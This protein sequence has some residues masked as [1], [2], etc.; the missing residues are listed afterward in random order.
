MTNSAHDATARNVA[1]GSD[2]ASRLFALS[3]GCPAPAHPDAVVE[4]GDARFT[5]LTD[6]L[7]RIEHRGATPQR[8]GGGRGRGHGGGRG[9]GCGCGGRLHAINYPTFVD[10]RTPL[11]VSRAFPVPEFTVKRGAEDDAVEITTPHLRL[12]YAGGPLTAS[13]LTIA[14]TSANADTH[15]TVWRYGMDL[16]TEWPHRGNLATTARTLDGVDGATE[17]EPGFLA[18]WGFGTLDDSGSPVLTADGWIAPSPCAPDAVDMYFFGHGR[19]YAGA[20]DDFHTLTGPIPM[21]PRYV[22]G[23]WWSRY[24]KYDEPSYLA[25]LDH[26]AAEDIPLSVAVIDMDWHWVDIDPEIGTG[27]TGYSWNTDLFPDPPR[28]LNAVHERGLA[29]TL[30]VHPADGV[31]RHEDAYEAIAKRLGVDPESGQ[32]IEF[33]I[34]DREF[35]TAYF[36]E[37]HHPLE[38]QGVDFWWLDWQSGG[39]TSMPGLDPLWLLNHA[40]YRDSGRGGRRPLTFSRY[41]GPGSHRYPVGFSGDTI[42][43]WDSLDFQPYF[44][45]TAANVG[46]PWWSHDIGGHMN[47]VRDNEMATRW[48]QL[49]CFSPINRLHSSNSPFTSKEPWAYG[50]HA[51]RIMG[52]YLRLRHRL[53]PYLYTAA[54][55]THLTNRSMVRPMYHE[56]PYERAA[57]FCTRQSTFGEDLLLIPITSPEDGDAHLATARGWLPEGVWHDIFTGGVYR[58]GEGGRQVAFNRPLEQ[59]PVL[60]RAGAVLPLQADPAWDVR[61]NPQHLELR[62]IPGT[63]SSELAED[64]VAGVPTAAD[65]RR[66]EFVQ[67]LDVHDDGTADLTLEIRTPE[68]PAYGEPRRVTIDLAGVAKAEQVRVVGGVVAH[69]S[70]DATDS[71]G[72]VTQERVVLKVAPHEDELLAPSLRIELGEVDLDAGLTVYV[73][74]AQRIAKDLVADAFALL[75]RAEIGFD[76]KEA[77]WAATRQAS[78]LDLATSLAAVDLPQVLRDAILEAAGTGQAW[79]S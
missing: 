52:R 40:H 31:R 44:T 70:G 54:W 14:L 26:F 39:A 79:R 2:D 64:D 46:Y 24:W 68:G 57:Y 75:D 53:V 35:L 8:G 18:T 45:A 73:T 41:S 50:P 63:G 32:R 19:D 4:V 20:L 76:D 66:T 33:D 25:L 27:W 9:G 61:C 5:V 11:V 36:E 49:G 47:G 74:G 59:Y 15:Y 21:V 77:A 23:N 58:A 13:S 38:D 3:D 60:A 29:T 17:L 51:E 78:G 37:L 1:S 71:E 55:R 16:P 48:F 67:T 22:L 43:T 65:R 28:F 34:T 7:I 56:H 12:R 69:E 42:I 30:N 62:V 10:A 72:E 6:R